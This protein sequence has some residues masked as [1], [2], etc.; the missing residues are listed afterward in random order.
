MKISLIIF[1]VM[2]FSVI[3]IYFIGKSLPEESEVVVEI[4]INAKPDRVWSVM[5]SWEKQPLWRSGIERVKVIDSSRFVEIPRNG[6]P[7][8]FHV[9]TADEPTLLRMEFRGS[10]SGTYMAEL[11]EAD[12]ATVFRSSESVSITNPF[13]RVLSKLFFD[14]NEFAENYQSELKSYVESG[15]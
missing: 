8:E 15:S 9:L 2:A 7:I 12:G 1:S 13:F 14:L 6:G 5:T 4:K 3:V 11:I 10:V